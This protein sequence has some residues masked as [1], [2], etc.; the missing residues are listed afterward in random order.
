MASYVDNS[1]RQAVMLN[2]AERTQQVRRT[3]HIMQ[4]YHTYM[5]AGMYVYMHVRIC[6]YIY[7]HMCVYLYNIYIMLI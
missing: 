7:T 6:I 3:N 5:C 4:I 2:P 1:F